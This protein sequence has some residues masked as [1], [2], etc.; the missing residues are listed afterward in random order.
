M[1]IEDLMQR[2]LDKAGFITPAPLQRGRKELDLNAKRRSSIRLS[3]KEK[4]RDLCVS[5]YASI[6]RRGVLIFDEKIF[7]VD[8]VIREG[9]E[10]LVQHMF[11]LA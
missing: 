8:R 9:V 3:K 7:S 5:T 2:S 4:G 10:I 6:L 11:G 1:E